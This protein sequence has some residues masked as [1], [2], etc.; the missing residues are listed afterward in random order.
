MVIDPLFC[1]EVGK[2]VH[3]FCAKK[4]AARHLLKGM[5]G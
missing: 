4:E 5:G 1:G 2:D 3:C